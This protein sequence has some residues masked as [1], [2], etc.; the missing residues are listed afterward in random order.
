MKGMP[1]VFLKKDERDLGVER[2]MRD[3]MF[4]SCNAV[5]GREGGAKKRR[6]EGQKTG[7]KTNGKTTGAKQKQARARPLAMYGHVPTTD[8]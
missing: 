5:W 2:G 8:Y 3:E 4:L 6:G 1:D 7:Y